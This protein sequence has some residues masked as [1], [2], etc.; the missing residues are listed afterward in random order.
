MAKDPIASWATVPWE[1]NI[2]L[3]G[4]R[5]TYSKFQRYDSGCTV[6]RKHGP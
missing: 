3:S 1:L 2:Q 4:S 6:L 5:I